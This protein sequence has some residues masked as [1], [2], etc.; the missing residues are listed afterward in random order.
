MEDWDSIKKAAELL[1]EVKDI[2]D[3]LNILKTLLTQQ[4]T[5][6]YKLIGHAPGTEDSKGPADILEEIKEM[7]KT[8]EGIH[9][10]VNLLCPLMKWQ[11]PAK[12]P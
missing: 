6:W 7:D 3:E 4:K 5:V 11:K 1:K 8:S 2:R 12:K 9:A 10:A